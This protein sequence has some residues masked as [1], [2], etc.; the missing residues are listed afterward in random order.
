MKKQTKI[1]SRE[2][3]KY[4]FSLLMIIGGLI[5]NIFEIGKNEFVG[6]SSVGSWLIYIGF[7]GIIIITLKVFTNK[8][9]IVD[10]R[11][12]FIANKAMRITFLALV[13]FAFLIMILDGINKIT[14]PYHLF[15]SYLICGLM[16]VYFIS[17][18]ILLRF[19]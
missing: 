3:M 14:T 13:I 9:R 10:E 11:M 5:L 8:N 7:I 4:S 1:K 15:M 2:L 18:K 16:F 6:F 19:Y 12:I 17:Y